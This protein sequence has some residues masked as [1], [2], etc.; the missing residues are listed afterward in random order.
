MSDDE[1]ED[2]E[3]EGFTK[4]EEIRIKG[5]NPTCEAKVWKKGERPYKQVFLNSL[6]LE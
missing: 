1:K 5:I 2:Y 3:D 6:P 4:D